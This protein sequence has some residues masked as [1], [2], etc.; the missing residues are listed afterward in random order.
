MIAI[1]Y[2]E[3]GFSADEALDALRSQIDTDGQLGDNTDRVDGASA[4]PDELLA[5][6]RTMPFLSARRLVVV[7]G[8]LGRFEVAGRRGRRKDSGLGVWQPFAEGVRELPE[9]TALVFIDGKL[10]AQNAL[11]RA[12]RPLADTRE[13]KAL[14]QNQIAMW[15]NQRAQQRGLA[16]EARATAALAS[17]VGAD[18]RTLDSE[19]AKLATFADGQPVTEDDV[20]S[21]V[22]LAREPNVFAWAD[23]VVEGRTKDA[24]ELLQRLLDESEPPQRL[25]TMLSRQYRLLLL[26]KEL[27]AKRVRPPEVASGLGVPPFVAQRLLKQAPSYTIERLR[28]AYR[29]LL[30]AD[31][32]IKRG[33]YDDETALQLLV[34]ELANAAARRASA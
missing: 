23:A 26:T 4:K 9:T 33:V 2:G 8:L 24:S 6:C 11:L 3:D 30:E 14:P 34:V 12:L 7:R 10:G 32:S 5:L 17:L 16:V 19:L 25:L 15:I 28:Q 18:L 21:L 1:F 31:L 13:F 27:Q 20:R 22:S 29:K